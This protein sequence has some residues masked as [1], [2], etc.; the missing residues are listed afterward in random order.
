MQ[1]YSDVLYIKVYLKEATYQEANGATDKNH[2]LCHG[3]AQ[4]PVHPFI[5][6]CEICQI[7]E[8]TEGGKR[9]L[10][11]PSNHSCINHNFRGG[12]LKVFMWQNLLF[13]CFTKNNKT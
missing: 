11:K 8:G 12:W 5:T 9:V 10:F 7:T 13:T 4:R 6:G 2:G 3:D 1:L